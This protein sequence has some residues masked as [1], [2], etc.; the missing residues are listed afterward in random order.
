MPQP[1]ILIAK[2]SDI[3]EIQRM[4]AILATE[5]IPAFVNDGTDQVGLNS[6]AGIDSEIFVPPQFKEQA[7][8]ALEDHEK[9]EEKPRTDFWESGENAG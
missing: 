1:W 7:L 2:R 4:K 5:N 6:G 3:Y 8:K 9:A